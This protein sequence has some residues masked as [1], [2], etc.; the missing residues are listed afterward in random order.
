MGKDH[1]Q[2][3][4]DFKDGAQKYKDM[5][6]LDTGKKYA[7]LKKAKKVVTKDSKAAGME[8]QKKERFIRTTRKAGFKMAEVKASPKASPKA[9]KSSTGAKIT[10]ASPNNVK[11]AMSEK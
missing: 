8:N 9:S 10:K 7:Q 6:S 1:K 4:I 11:N 3:N 2:K 5:N